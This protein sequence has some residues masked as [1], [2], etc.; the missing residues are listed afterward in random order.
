MTAALEFRRFGSHAGDLQIDL[1]AVRPHVMTDALAACALTEVDRE[2][3]WD[4]S[5]G[6][7]IEYLLTLTGADE[8]DAELRC[9]ACGSVFEIGLT[10]A[11]LL[12]AAAAAGTGAI[13]VGDARFRRPA[14]RDQLAWLEHAR[15]DDATLTDHIIATLAL[16]DGDCPLAQLEAA[17]EEADPLLRAPVT[18]ACPECG[19]AE[20]HDTDPTGMALNH[21]TRAQD[22]LLAAVDALASHYHWSEAEILALPDWRR[23]RYLQ[24][25]QTGVS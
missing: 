23:A 10:V 9:A 19:H 2:A 14:G 15:T 4:L 21:L 22:A 6:K 5:V 20:E 12:D 11:E 3:L 13:Q 25:I 17:F 1:T 16:D 8:F 18:A 24:M 7:R